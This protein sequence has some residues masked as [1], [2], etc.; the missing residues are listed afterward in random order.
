MWDQ[1]AIQLVGN[2]GGD[3]ELRQTSSGESVLNFR[4]AVTGRKQEN[5]KY[6]DAETT[7]Y[8]VA[9]FKNADA[10]AQ[11]IHKGTRVATAGRFKVSEYE[12]DGVKRS[13]PEVVAD[14]VAV[15][16]RAQQKRE[17]PW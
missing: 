4:V 9:L 2:V 11:V 17:D 8:A 15:V 5:G 7:W 3:P 13:K 14:W 6:V 10:A 12:K 16:P 1:A